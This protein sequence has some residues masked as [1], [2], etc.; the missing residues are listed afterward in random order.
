MCGR[1]M[2]QP[3]TSPEIDRIYRLAQT[4]GYFPKVGEVFPNDQTALIVAGSHQVQIKAIKWGFPGFKDK[5]VLINA[6]AETAE[7]KKMFAKAFATKRCVYPTTG[8]FEWTKQKDKIWF[9]YRQTPQPLYIAGFYDNFEGEDRSILLTTTP[10]DSVV[11]VHDR[12]PLIL[13]KNQINRWI[14]Q[15]DFAHNFLTG[16]MP[17][18]ENKEW[19]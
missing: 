16:K 5:Q 9:N 4:A 3:D 18:L 8:F 14:Y 15:R 10:N 1:F 11:S 2:F 7:S 6:R 13:S 12:M 17:Q 19:K